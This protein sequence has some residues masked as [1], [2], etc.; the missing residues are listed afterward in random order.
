MDRQEVLAAAMNK[1]RAAADFD[2]EVTLSAE[3][4]YAILR[5]VLNEKYRSGRIRPLDD[6]GM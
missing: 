3:E 5:W 1:I 4:A 2:V 6:K